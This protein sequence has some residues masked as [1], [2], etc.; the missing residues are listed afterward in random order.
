[1]AGPCFSVISPIR[2]KGLLNMPCFQSSLLGLMHI[3]ILPQ[4]ISSHSSIPSV[5][6]SQSHQ[7]LPQSLWELQINQCH[8]LKAASRDSARDAAETPDW[9]P[10]HGVR[11]IC[12][13]KCEGLSLKMPPLIWL[14]GKRELFTNNWFCFSSLA[15]DFRVPRTHSCLSTLT[16]I[17][18]G[19]GT[20][21][22]LQSCAA[23]A[24]VLLWLWSFAIC[25]MQIHWGGELNLCFNHWE[26]L[27]RIPAQRSEKKKEK[28]SR[29]PWEAKEFIPVFKEILL[30]A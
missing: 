1:M 19:W 18:Q 16:T 22:A 7:V 13:C 26:Q 2:G 24:H 11:S 20:G 6:S 12:L 9:A 29:K 5:L 4:C 27:K 23:T 28:E 30:F 25:Y 8:C 15:E 10:E 21:L 3:H 14:Q 17:R